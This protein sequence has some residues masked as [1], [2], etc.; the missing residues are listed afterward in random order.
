M[1]TRS[2]ALV[3]ATHAGAPETV[4]HSS[5]AAQSAS[6]RQLQVVPLRLGEPHPNANA[7]ANARTKGTGS[8]SSPS[9]ACGRG[10]G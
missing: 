6:V 7:N 1:P 8:Q 10:P 4:P 3:A 2:G 5:P 9:P